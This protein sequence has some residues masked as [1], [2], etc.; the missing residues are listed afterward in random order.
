MNVLENLFFFCHRGDR[1]LIDGLKRWYILLVFFLPTLGDFLH[2]QEHLY[3]SL[4]RRAA[5]HGE[6]VLRN[7]AMKQHGGNDQ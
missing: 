5:H 4:F 2:C 3:I 7:N 1:Y 6:G